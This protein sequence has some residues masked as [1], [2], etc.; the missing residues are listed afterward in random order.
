VLAV[1]LGGSYTKIA[2]QW[3]IALRWPTVNGAGPQGFVFT[4][5]VDGQDTTA[6]GIPDVGASRWNT[7]APDLQGKL[8][9][10]STVGP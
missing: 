2:E 1:D 5:T 7:V 6:I 3:Q 4:V 10:L 8:R 9:S